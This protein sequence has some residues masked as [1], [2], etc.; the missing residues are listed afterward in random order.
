MSLARAQSL[1]ARGRGDAALA[2]LDRTPVSESDPRDAVVRARVLR[3]CGR[4]AEADG[5][6]AAATAAHPANGPVLV[7]AGIAALEAGDA[8]AAE[9]ALLRVMEQQPENEIARSHLALALLAQGRDEEGLAIFRGHGFSDNLG[10]RARLTEWMERQWLERG[11]FFSPTPLPPPPETAVPRGLFARMVRDRRAE[12][13]FFSKRFGEVVE[14]VH[15]AVMAP[16]PEAEIVYAC[17]IAAEMEGDP[18][19]ALDYVARAP[20]PDNLPDA[21]RA[22]RARCLVRTGRFEEAATDLNS[23]LILGPEDFGVNYYLGVLCL[24]FGNPDRARAC[25]LR[26]HGEYMIDTLEFQWWQIERALLGPCAG[27]VLPEPSG[28]QG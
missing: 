19:R 9:T 5:L 2:E 4:G 13:A 18:R 6:L 1:L 17:A 21:L 12:R 11:R 28:L 26:A 27:T 8:P 10:F 24:A 7:S 16:N 23:I 14:V 20:E 3:A 25:F 15:P 22:V